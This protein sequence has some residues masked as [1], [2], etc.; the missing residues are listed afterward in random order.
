MLNILLT[1]IGG[2]GTVLAAKVLAQ[3]AHNKGWHMR[4]AETIG[5]AQRG[6]S[7]VSHVRIGNKGETVHEP[8]I[9]AHSA[10]LIIAFEP[11]EAVRVLPYLSEEGFLVT[12]T[13]AVQ[14]V[15]ATL[16]QKRY[17]AEEMLAYLEKVAP[18]FLAIDDTALCAEAETRKVLNTLLLAS[19]LHAH[20]GEIGINELRDA[21]K[22]S[23][24]KNYIDMNLKAIDIAVEAS[25]QN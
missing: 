12:A 17:C 25:N 2:Q 6:G 23:V 16:S 5:M 10:D 7:V 15:S 1:G 11:S 21:I 20:E 13:S 18:R 8:L 19:A 14:P 3:A 24:K 22:R 9:A 4:T